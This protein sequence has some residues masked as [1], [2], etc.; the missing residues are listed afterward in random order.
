MWRNWKKSFVYTTRLPTR[1]HIHQWLGAGNLQPT[2][3]T[4]EPEGTD[5][6]LGNWLHWAF[7]NGLLR[8]ARDQVCRIRYRARCRRQYQW[9]KDTIREPRTLA[10]LLH[11]T[12]CEQ[13]T[14]EGN[15]KRSRNSR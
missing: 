3:K 1:E 6:S 2:E 15:V 14:Y 4:P 10:R 7:H 11:R 8:Q 13:R 5:R 12:T 9:G